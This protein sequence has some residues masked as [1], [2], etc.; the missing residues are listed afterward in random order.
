MMRFKSVLQ[1]SVLTAKS[2]GCGRLYIY[3]IHVH[4]I[5]LCKYYIYM[6]H[7]ICNM[8]ILHLFKYFFMNMFP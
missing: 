6:L 1:M 5:C 7:V 2:A 8:Y 4:I 3:I